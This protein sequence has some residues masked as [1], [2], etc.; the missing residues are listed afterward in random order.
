MERLAGAKFGRMASGDVKKHRSELL[1]FDAPQNCSRS[2]M[3]THKAQLVM[4]L[5]GLIILPAASLRKVKKS[6]EIDS[7]RCMH[8]LKWDT[9]ETEGT[10]KL[11]N[12]VKGAEGDSIKVVRT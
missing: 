9:V 4:G 10:E 3:T 5:V 6:L 2:S 1:P 7:W 8:L 11:R 12:L